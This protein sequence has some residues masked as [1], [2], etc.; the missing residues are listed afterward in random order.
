MG[1]GSCQLTLLW[2]LF[3]VLLGELLGGLQELL[4]LLDELLGQ[5]G[6]QWVL[7]LR[8][9]DD[10][11]QGLQ[12]VLRPRGGFPVV[13]INDR[14]AHLALLVHVRMVDLRLE[15]DL[16]GHEGVLGREGDLD[17]EGALVVRR[18]LRNEQAR[19]QQQGLVAALEVPQRAHLGLI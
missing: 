8:V 15:E 11:H 4:V 6:A 3:R 14:Q 19:P 17:A 10:G 5:V 7:R 1:S 16:R 12:H 2:S 18:L 13:G 9:V